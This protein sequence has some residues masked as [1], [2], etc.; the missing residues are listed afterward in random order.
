MR[1]GSVYVLVL[2]IAQCILLCSSSTQSYQSLSYFL[3]SYL[4]ASMLPLIVQ[5]EEETCIDLAVFVTFLR[6][7]LCF[8]YTEVTVYQLNTCALTALFP[9]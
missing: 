1:V 6:S 8:D 5:W 9:N 4:C 3:S 2:Y 7:C